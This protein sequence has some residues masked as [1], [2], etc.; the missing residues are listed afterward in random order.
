LTLESRVLKLGRPFCHNP[1]LWPPLDIAHEPP[2]MGVSLQMRHDVR[3]LIVIV[4]LGVP[5]VPQ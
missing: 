5:H 1:V 2:V 4:V 3:H